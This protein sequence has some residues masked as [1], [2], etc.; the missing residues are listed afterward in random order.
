MEIFLAPTIQ[1]RETEK[2][3]TFNYWIECNECLKVCPQN[4][5]KK[6]GG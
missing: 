6:P 3:D 1:F 5:F 4:R 2:P